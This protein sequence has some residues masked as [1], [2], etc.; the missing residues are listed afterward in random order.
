MG[1]PSVHAS[2]CIH[3]L[4]I[5]W[6]MDT[7]RGEDRIGTVSASLETSIECA[8]GEAWDQPQQKHIF[9]SPGDSGPPANFLFDVTR[10][11]LPQSH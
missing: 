1:I 5:S 6:K 7:N 9:M 4:W 11:S 3:M 8:G 10:W 2:C